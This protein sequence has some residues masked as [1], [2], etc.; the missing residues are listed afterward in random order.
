MWLEYVTLAWN[1][2]GVIV[3]ATAALAAHSVAL[4]GFGLDSLIEIL[5]STVVIWQLTDAGGTRERV[6]MRIIG[7]AFIALAI[8]VATQGV[9]LLVTGGR[10]APS[11]LGIAWTAATCAVM[12][13]LAFGKARTGA[14][15]GNAAGRRSSDAHRRLSCGRR[16]AGIVDQRCA[17]VVV[18]GPAGGFRH[19]VYGVR[20]GWAALHH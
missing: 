20:E 7:G 6:A 10:P 12:L 18:G 15:L 4:A 1:V 2:V 19:R 5:A 14:A 3:L 16:P 17:R 8:Y 13:C 9:Y 11:L